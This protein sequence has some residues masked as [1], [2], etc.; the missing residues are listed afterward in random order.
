MTERDPFAELHDWQGPGRSTP[1]R[2]PPSGSGNWASGGGPADT[3][4]QLPRSPWSLSPAAHCCVRPRAA[5]IRC[6][7][8]WPRRARFPGLPHPAGPR[9]GRGQSADRRRQPGPTV[10]RPTPRP[11]RESAGVRR[12]HG[13]LTGGHR[14]EIGAE[15]VLRRN[16]RS[17][18]ADGRPATPEPP[19]G[20]DP[21]IYTQAPQ[22]HSADA[23]A[24]GVRDTEAGD[25]ARKPSRDAGDTCRCGAGVASGADQGLRRGGPVHR[26]DLDS[27]RRR[28]RQRYF[29]S[30]GLALVGDRLAVTVS[31]VYG[32]V[33]NV[34]YDQDGDPDLG[35]R[36]TRSTACWSPRRP[37]DPL[38][39]RLP[40]PGS[41]GG[42]PS[43]R[44]RADRGGKIGGV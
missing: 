38:R 9:A 36:R 27:R 37:V 41:D 5:P 22:F 35:P 23:S 7:T 44:C 30:V 18:L 31:L 16:F 29:E 40:A 2:C 26:G 13:L 39:P 14:S 12:R 6:P 32:Q 33:Y 10:R 28:V 1:R 34:A 4:L 21:T 17:A 3:V 20:S 15:D 11:R 8:P 19:V 24:C 42:S 25:L 43:S